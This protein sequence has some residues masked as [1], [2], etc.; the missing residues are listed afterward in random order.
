MFHP[1]VQT[2]FDRSFAEA[3]PVQLA[4]WQEIDQGH[5]VLIAA[6]TGSGK[7][8]AAFLCAI[9]RLVLESRDAVLAESVQVLYVSPL[10]ALSNDI[11]KNLQLPL[12]G[13]ESWL[14]GQGLGKAGIRAM[15][16]TG[17]TTP[18]EREQMRRHPPQILVTTPESLYLLLTSA[19]GRAMLST[20]QEVIV[21]EIHA[22][23]ASKRGS[24]LALSL[25]RLDALLPRP[26]RRIGL[27]ATQKP[28]DEI[29]NFLTGGRSCRIV[30]VGHQRKRD[31][32]L[33]IPRSPL[34][35]VMA[36]EV[37]DEIYGQLQE[38]VE[39]HKTTLIFVNTRRL[40]ER[41]ARHLAE[42]LADSLGESAVTAHHGSL[43]REH[44]LEAEQALKSGSLRAL[45]AT[46]SLE[47]GI[48][49]GSVDLVCQLGSPGSISA[50]IQR[51]G[52]AGHAVGEIPKG[53]LF[54]LSRDDLIESIALLRSVEQGVLDQIQIPQAPL[55]VLAQQLVAEL[56]A[57]D[58]DTEGL[59]A[60][61]RTAWP[62]RQ[63][64]RS[65]FDQML[66]MLSNG[67]A[68]RRGRH[69]AYLHH[70]AVN[71]FLRARPLARLT[72]LQNGGAIP[73]QFDYDVILQP[74]GYRVGT[75]NE[76]FAFES[77]PGDIFQLGNNSYR[78]QKVEQNRVLVED[79]HGQPPTIPFW[80]G[81][82]AGR[83][84][85]LSA[86]VS[87]LREELQSR[88]RTQ[89]PAEVTAW[90]NLSLEHQAAAEQAVEYM[91][92][93][94]QAL[95]CIPTRQQMVLERFF[96][97]TGDMHLIIHAPLGSRIMRAWGLALRKRFCR[98]FNFELQAAAL[99]DCLIL[100][101]GETHSFDRD[102]V[103][104]FLHSA[105]VREVLVQALLDA[106]MFGLR[107]RWNAT[108][109]L[110]VQRMRN[111]KK[112]PPQWQRNQAEDL[113]AVVFPDQLAC[114]E[115]IRGEREIPDHPLVSQTISDCLNVT[116]DI[117]GLEQILLCRERGE[118]EIRSVD[119][120]APSPL[121]AEIINARP[122]AF[123]DDGDAENRRTRA[124][125]QRGNDLV[126]PAMLSIIS[127]SSVE[128]A[129]AECW[130]SPRNPD[131]L[132]D[133]LL[134]LGFLTQKEFTTGAASTGASGDARLW[135]RWFQALTDDLRATCVS[136]DEGSRWWVATE[137]LA[138]FLAM[139]E[140]RRFSPD[141]GSNWTGKTG[142][143][144]DQ[145]LTEILR[146]RLAGL[147]PVTITQLVEDF[148]LPGSRMEQG[149]LALQNE[150]YAMT[151]DAL[152]IKSGALRGET[153]QAGPDLPS[154][155]A[156]HQAERQTSG[157]T[158]GQTNGQTSG[159]T[160]GLAWCERRLLARIHRYS[161][162]TRRQSAQAVSPAVFM[163]F[164][165]S[166]HGLDQP[167]AEL[168]PVLGMLEGWSA[169][170]TA[171]ESDL[172]PARCRHYSAQA[173]DALFLSGQM[174]WFRPVQGANDRQQVVSATPIAIVPRLLLPAW[175]GDSPVSCENLPESAAG[176]LQC[177]QQQ[178]AMFTDDLAGATGLLQP[179]LE[180]VLG[181]LVARGL[182][183]ADAFSPLRW[184]VRPE[185]QKRRQLR[186]ARSS[187]H[188]TSAGHSGA[189]RLR[190]RHSVA[191]SMLG[192]WSLFTASRP[193]SI[194]R[195][196][197]DLAL[198]C[199]ALLRRYG[200]VFRALLE[201]ETLIPCWRDL[202]LYFR[203]MEDRGEVL[204]GRF[205][206]GFSGEQFAL[207]EALGLL[208]NTD[209]QAG[210]ADQRVIAA[211][212]PLNLGG[213][214]TP[215]VKT[216][217]VNGHRILLL[218]G[219]PVARLQGEGVEILDNNFIRNP[220]QLRQ[221]LSP[222]RALRPLGALGSGSSSA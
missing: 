54:P 192:R 20:V 25:A 93:V 122:Y 83:S 166:W 126:D 189:G 205:V 86:A 107:W 175:L 74:Q 18:G 30:N 50:F 111:G 186:A 8:F 7:T 217:A 167:A 6:P 91:A 147:G 39:T 160:N 195:E 193:A 13:I 55:D 110:A 85:E 75:L 145:A 202:L 157:Q 115:N 196:Q 212:D 201:R 180:Q 82:A 90:L 45:V 71:G 92:A 117:A 60:L 183:T 68:S 29:A 153:R 127:R 53:R 182:V 151:M 139:Q 113:V 61:V 67:Y 136:A 168:Q 36:N 105:S 73:D 16:R 152:S 94:L 100:S 148:S 188:A 159:Q 141:P 96:D 103:P 48:D 43:S 3:T 125:S 102:A 81:D 46:A 15:V 57:R 33:E 78:I 129:Q 64:E 69:S 164:L 97:D 190:A 214:I 116:M 162:E 104:A 220:E 210:R 114:L 28:I 184:L 41:V 172:L 56:S 23:A 109:A 1:A 211:T 10:K 138:E 179:Q 133:G 72:A 169:P 194:S 128:Q 21:D 121:A 178:G 27:S 144:P 108:I 161:R 9:N 156:D 130:I 2:W 140:G 14:A 34:S 5:D 131:E 32:R 173:L 185:Q 221:K 219:L 76:D 26:A 79:A 177:L 158:S 101:L 213:I 137:R 207:A 12:Q 120:V 47:L 4:A 171:W 38:L 31:L 24:H 88:L 222:V 215:G 208:K 209:R 42:R 11:E 66:D 123:L 134:Q 19:S 98:H 62:Y 200:V 52:R 176:V 77:L 154:P 181:L 187:G 191:S 150:G 174:A 80:V 155:L 63:L 112:L 51:V 124:I 163:R 146:S 198:I 59:Y 65:A 44:R 49:I 35:A 106:P 22:V 58:W 199:Q 143:D 203:R 99:E 165:L 89:P 118:I 84:D 204:G 119:L 87:G 206:D 197:D 170:M 95:G 132:H 37:W 70:D 40:A 218:D 149:L 135:G 17:D 142:Q 216:P